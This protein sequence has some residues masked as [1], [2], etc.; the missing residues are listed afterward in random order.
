MYGLHAVPH[1]AVLVLTSTYV[2]RATVHSR[3]QCHILCHCTD[4]AVYFAAGQGDAVDIEVLTGALVSQRKAFDTAMQ[5]FRSGVFEKCRSMFDGSSAE[6]ESAAGP[7]QETAGSSRSEPSHPGRRDGSTATAGADSSSMDSIPGSAQVPELSTSG[8]GA[9]QMPGQL[10]DH[11][12]TGHAIP[13]IGAAT[14][15]TLMP[16]ATAK[17]QDKAAQ[18]R[19]HEDAPDEAPKQSNL[20]LAAQEAKQARKQAKR[21]RQR[22]RRAQGTAASA[23]GKVCTCLWSCVSTPCLVRLKDHHVSLSGPAVQEAVHDGD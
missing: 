22:A 2:A 14:A 17:T 6:S 21:A 19:G 12:R 18:S 7:R 15:T 16:E 4:F 3:F 9:R 1:E 11:S 13:D 23:G 10:L 8:K 5:S 20:E